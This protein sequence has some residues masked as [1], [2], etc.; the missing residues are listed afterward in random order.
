MQSLLYAIAILFSFSPLK[1]ESELILPREIYGPADSEG[2]LPQMDSSQGQ[3]A[4]LPPAATVE[5][6]GSVSAPPLELIALNRKGFVHRGRREAQIA[7][8]EVILLQTAARIYSPSQSFMSLADPKNF[9]FI[10]YPQSSLSLLP[11]NASWQIT[12]IGDRGLIRLST[13]DQAMSLI[14]KPTDP[15]NSWRNMALN[16]AHQSDLFIKYDKN[17]WKTFVVKGAVAHQFEAET[18]LTSNRHP[19]LLRDWE[20]SQRNQLKLTIYA[21]QTLNLNAGSDLSYTIALPRPSEWQ[22]PILR[23]SPQLLQNQ[24]AGNRLSQLFM[25]LRSTFLKK[26]LNK[27]PMDKSTAQKLV[28]EGRWEEAQT[29]VRLVKNVESS[30]HVD[31]LNAWESLCL[32]RLQQHELAIKR[33]PP[34]TQTSMYA[35]PLKLEQLRSSL[36]EHSLTE[37]KY[38]KE[39]GLSSLST[40]ELYLY[41]STQQRQEHWRE[42]L[43]FWEQW[44]SDPQDAALQTSFKEWVSHL[45]RKKPLSWKGTVSWGF[46]NNVLHLPSGEAAPPE[47]GRR[48]SWF[49]SSTHRLPYRLER[50]DTFHLAVEGLLDFTIFPY[51]TLSEIQRVQSGL[52]LPILLK[53]SDQQKVTLRPFISRLMMGSQ[54]GLDRFGYS[55]S[56]GWPLINWK[57][58][59]S[60]SQDQNLDYLPQNPHRL[61][62]LSGERVDAVDRSVRR[63]SLSLGLEIPAWSWPLVL[64]LEDWNY[65]YDQSRDDSRQ[66]IGLSSFVTKDMPWNTRWTVRLALNQDRFTSGSSRAPMMMSLLGLE[67]VY[68][69]SYRLH[70]N[71]IMEREAYQSPEEARSWSELRI[72]LGLQDRW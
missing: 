32:F 24:E 6:Q 60:W 65:R 64:S 46:A 10:L 39:Q 40:D 62:A 66:R 44:P 1:A 59:F 13:L 17:Q 3:N 72:S 47:I 45:D 34:L 12:L 31:E 33:L 68:L 27:L 51:S 18:P 69:W 2:F 20:D 61:D 70:P 26:S 4:A 5:E 36:R 14:V 63:R 11:I 50:S 21:G 35:L 15:D 56:Y 30:D 58:E 38:S 28:Q 71:L 52:A 54:S 23:S 8:Q 19:G 55:L 41:A 37:V 53:L 25:E 43:D 22:V 29:V 9:L 49:L 57:P 7:S 16:I 42:A 48:S 67:G